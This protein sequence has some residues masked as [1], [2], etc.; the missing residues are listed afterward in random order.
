MIC[1][2][3]ERTIECVQYCYRAISLKLTREITL[4]DV[5]RTFCT[6]YFP[7]CVRG[8]CRFLIL[9][10]TMNYSKPVSK[11]NNMSAMVKLDESI[12]AAVTTLRDGYVIIS[13]VFQTKWTHYENALSWAIAFFLTIGQLYLL[14][15][16]PL[17]K[18]LRPPTYN[19]LISSVCFRVPFG[20]NMFKL[21]RSPSWHV[22][23]QEFFRI[24]CAC[25]LFPPP[26][27]TWSHH[28]TLNV[29]V[30]QN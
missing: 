4:Y 5:I 30:Q 8:G 19:H 17:A 25:K 6:S 21:G 18:R 24:I 11:I 10:R 15:G 14:W 2:L 1:N 29:T 3:C 23:C 13:V 12:Y 7:C 16:T 20:T 9:S 26:V 27:I 22:L 28:K